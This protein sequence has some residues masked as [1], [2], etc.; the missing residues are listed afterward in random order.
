MSFWSFG[1]CRGD[2]PL[3]RPVLAAVSVLG[4]LQRVGTAAH[5]SGGTRKAS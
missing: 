4:A 2:G 1:A 3:L 5:E